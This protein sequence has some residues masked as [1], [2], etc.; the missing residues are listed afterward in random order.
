MQKTVNVEGQNWD[1]EGCNKL[2]QSEEDFLISNID[3]FGYYTNIKDKQKR[4]SILKLVWK[5]V[6][7][8]SPKPLQTTEKSIVNSTENSTEKE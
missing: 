8:N 7:L 1:V 5:T 2:W 3:D 4:E 6:Q